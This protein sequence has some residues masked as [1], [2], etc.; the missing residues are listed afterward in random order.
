ME[1]SPKGRW[2][3]KI[4]LNMAKESYEDSGISLNLDNKAGLLAGVIYEYSLSEQLYFGSGLLFSQKGGKIEDGDSKITETLNYIDI[5]FN[6]VF[7]ADLKGPKLLVEAGPQIGVGIS[8][9][10]K[11]EYMGASENEDIE[12]GSDEDQLKRFDFGLN[13]G[14]GVEYDN[15]QLK[16]NYVIGLSD[17]SNFDD[18][19]VKNKVLGISLSYFF[20]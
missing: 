16:V 19:S 1:N 5:P 7:K 12:F 18:G 4:G 3:I 6:L 8:G 11:Y 14:G 9:K 20:D 10:D 2:G 13:L 17:I 15:F